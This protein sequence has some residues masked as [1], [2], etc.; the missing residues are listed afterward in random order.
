MMIV[1]VK[2]AIAMAEATTA[3]ITANWAILTVSGFGLPLLYQI[4]QMSHG[5]WVSHLGM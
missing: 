3:V 5:A 4:I 1:G 2:A